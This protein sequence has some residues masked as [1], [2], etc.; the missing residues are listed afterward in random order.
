[1][2][3]RIWKDPNAQKN[4][5]RGQE[6][7]GVDVYGQPNG[8]SAW[9]G[10]QCKGKD[11]YADKKV[12]KEELRAEVEKAKSFQPAL[13]QFILATTGPKDAAVEQLARELTALQQAQGLFSV[14]VMGWEDI[15]GLLDNHHDLID[16]Y[17]RVETATGVVLEE[18]RASE[19]RMREFIP[20]S[21][22]S[23][24]LSPII[25]TADAQTV[26]LS[27][28]HQADLDYA[29]SLLNN[30]QPA[31]ALQYLEDFRKRIWATAVPST[32]YRLLTLLGTA[33]LDL[34]RE[35]K[36]AHLFVES[37]QYRP[38]ELDAMGYAAVGFA[39]LGHDTEAKRL[40]EEV[41]QRNP[42]HSTAW[43]VKVELS[44]VEENL[45]NIVDRIPPSLRTSIDVSFALSRL[46]QRQGRTADVVT[47]L[48]VAVEHDSQRR[49]MLLASLGQHILFD[50]IQ[51]AR[52][53]FLHALTERQRQTLREAESLLTEA[54][55]L[56]TSDE[57]R[58]T[59]TRW[60]IPLAQILGL[61]GNI[62]SAVTII[63]RGLELTPDDPLLKYQRAMNAYDLG[64]FR[65]A[66]QLC[67]TLSLSAEAPR[68]DILRAEALFSMGQGDKAIEVV[69]GLVRRNPPAE[70][71]LDANRLLID[72]ALRRNDTA[73]ARLI[74]DKA[75]ASNPSNVLAFVDIA[76]VAKATGDAEGSKAHLDAARNSLPSPAPVPEAYLLAAEY[77]HTGHFDD[78][79][80]LYEQI[81]DLE[82]DSPLHVRLLSCYHQGGQTDKALQICERLERQH[83]PQR[84]TSEVHAS[85]LEEI[86]DLRGARDVLYKYVEAFPDDFNVRLRLAHTCMHMGNL[87][88]VDSFLAMCK[89]LPELDIEHTF[90]LAG[91]FFQRDQDLRGLEILYE[92]RRAHPNN[93][94]VHSQ[95]IVS[96]LGSKKD[97]LPSLAPSIIADGVAVKL[98]T[99]QEERWYV[100]RDRGDADSSRR[101]INFSHPLGESLQGKA[102]GDTI[103]QKPAAGL[104]IAYTVMEIQSNL[105]RALQESFAFLN[106]F[107]PQGEGFYALNIGTPGPEGGLP[108]GLRAI[109]DETEQRAKH[110]RAVEQLYVAGRITIGMFAQAVGRDVVEVVH[111][112]MSTP[113]GGVRCFSGNPQEWEDAITRLAQTPLLIAADLV[114]ILT[115]CSSGAAGK[116]VER[117]GK[118]HVAQDTLDALYNRIVE[119]ERL[120]VRGYMVISKE[121]GRYVRQ[122]I[123]PEA[124]AQ[125]IDFLRKILEWAKKNCEVAPSMRAL[126][127]PREQRATL[128]EALGRASIQTVLIASET[129]HVLLSDDGVLRQL[130]K[131]EY[132]AKGVWTQ[133]LL[134]YCQQ[135]GILT[136]EAYNRAVVFLA[137]NNFFYPRIDGAILLEAARLSEWVDCPLFRSVVRFLRGDW[138][139]DS[140]F[141][142]AADFL[143]QLWGQPLL[144]V[145]RDS[146]LTPLL[147]ALLRARNPVV[148]VRQLAGALQQRFRL[149]PLELNEVITAIGSRLPFQ[150]M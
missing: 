6:Q 98:L 5:R 17:C 65:T 67:E 9:A 93:P 20:E 133:P 51:D 70:I 27:G 100:I 105:V 28:E 1:L 136:L 61:L 23:V 94:R 115:I 18:M 84:Y 68:A 131:A 35:D 141:R 101:E 132:G 116:V 83:G 38:N 12:T 124:V 34:F 146:L 149:L 134:A 111:H 80:R 138:C 150:I 104:P 123:S 55:G 3:R 4:G 89:D 125:H 39:I 97:N 85:I 22:K 142:V 25:A 74:A 59:A 109:F 33:Q 44:N 72:L 75:L 64:D 143:Y 10:V 147:S 120:N 96:F 82:S 19:E 49:P 14:T 24:L 71:A 62:Q 11:N 121:Q 128:G 7:H 113:S 95:Y 73:K 99:G 16:R 108:P 29:R 90:I 58:R 86:G 60:L 91:L 53:K 140:A 77:F 54:W 102:I 50:L 135:D 126:E 8:G 46:A 148:A 110:G 145:R 56:L 48:R 47:W 112:L 63:D 43:A 30:H 37:L 137:S 41:L 127:I 69:E 15:L 103:T 119:Q 2:W 21:L 42:L 87:D 107:Y 52:V 66:A 130:A 129:N 88:E 76:R 40:I 45:Q 139:D 32:R 31:A 26:L 13:S 79:A 78:A 117:F 57:D 144:D 92:L 114:A 106:E 36:A 122:E 118:L 81:I